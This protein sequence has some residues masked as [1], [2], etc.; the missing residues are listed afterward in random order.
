MKH[1]FVVYISPRFESD[2]TTAILGKS[3]HP[4]NF[5]IML[6][7]ITL[8]YPRSSY[9]SESKSTVLDCKRVISFSFVWSP[10]YSRG[11]QIPHHLCLWQTATCEMRST[12]FI[13]FGVCLNI[14][15]V[16]NR[17]RIKAKRHQKRVLPSQSTTY[18]VLSASTI[19][20]CP[21]L[22]SQ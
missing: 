2:L 15:A 22:T 9:I 11:T 6:P 7:C 16:L 5:I 8:Q 18:S 14:S 1:I 3:I 17:K 13:F 12:W 19:Y 20:F 4:H 21:G 10:R